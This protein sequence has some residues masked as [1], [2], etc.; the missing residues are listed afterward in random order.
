MRETCAEP[1]GTGKEG[2]PPFAAAILAGGESRRMG[3]DKAE[4]LWGGE[5]FLALIAGKLNA[6]PDRMVATGKRERLIPEGWRPVPDVFRDCGPI[7][8]IHA[9]LR[10][11]RIPWVFV[12]SCD[13]PRVT[14]ELAS[15]L[16]E[17][18]L[19]ENRDR[20]LPEDMR[21]PDLAVPVTADGR[22]HMTCALWNRS[23]LPKLEIR[24]RQGDYR[25]YTLC[26]E[27]KTYEFPVEGYLAEMLEDIN[28]E[29]EYRR[30]TGGR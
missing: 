12:V 7:G 15:F 6:F 28:T 2:L 14:E 8:G 19:R 24:L 23:A 13:V 18:G 10:E 30:L 25:L 1:A 5:T 4:L 21:E 11:S 26:G 3:A 20:A 16:W 17:G 9:V 27:L 22:R 29:E